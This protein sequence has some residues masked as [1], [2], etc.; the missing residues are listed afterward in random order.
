M[1][2]IYNKIVI[3]EKPFL[4]ICV[5]MQVADKGYEFGEC[6]GLGLIKGSVKNSKQIN[7]PYQILD[8]TILQ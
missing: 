5:G 1:E 6:Q 2:E 7:I 8:G 4:G 3:N